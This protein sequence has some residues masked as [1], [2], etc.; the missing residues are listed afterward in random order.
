VWLWASAHDTVQNSYFFGT[1]NAASQSYGVESWPGTDNLVINNIFQQ[2]TTP[3][4]MGPSLG[5][6][7]AYNFSIYNLATCCFLYQEIASNHDA[8]A[9]YNL[10]EGNIGQGFIG[11]YFHGGGGLQ[12]FFRNVALGW[13]ST[14]TTSGTS[15]VRMDSYQRFQNVVGNV[16]GCNNTSSAVYPGNCGAP[17]Q[18]SYQVQAGAG[19]TANIYDLGSGASENISLCGGGT[20][21]VANDNYVATSMMRWGN[22]DTK[23]AANQF[24][25]AEVPTA[26]TDGYALSIPASHTLPASFYLS[27]K[28]SWWTSGKPWPAIGP[29]ITGGNLAGFGGRAYSNPAMDCYFNVMGGPVDGGVSSPGNPL[30]YNPTSCYGGGSSGVPLAPTGLTLTVY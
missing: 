30:A 6:V 9:M 14:P 18:T 12:T 23:N 27:S 24:N 8:A 1:Q 10:Y 29:D 7:F 3:I 22:Y 16:L 19:G 26:L 17:Y 15:A 25:S 20:C 28:P 13:D 4:M 5:S 11:D 2:V 21:T